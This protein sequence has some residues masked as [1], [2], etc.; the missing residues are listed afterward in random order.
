MASMDKMSVVAYPWGVDPVSVDDLVR[1]AQRAQDLGFYSVNVPY[2]TVAMEADAVFA[3]FSHNHIVDPVVV[4]T[5]MLRETHSIR[6]ASDGFPLSLLPP[7]HWAKTIATLEHMAPGRVIAGFCLGYGEKMF[8][9]YGATLKQR[10]SRSNEQ[11]EIITRL[12]SDPRVDHHG[13]H[14]H[15]EDMTC[16]PKPATAPPI[17]W[18][19][20]EKS[21]GR[22]ARYA[23]CLDLF[24]PPLEE[25]NTIALK[26]REEN[27]RLGTETELG[28]WV[29]THVEA[30]KSMTGEDIDT[31][32]AGYY[33][34]DER[35]AAP[36]PRDVAVAGDPRQCA[37]KIAEYEGLGLTR[38]VLD[39]QNHGV[40]PVDTGIAQMELFAE[41]VAPL[42]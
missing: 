6:I 39:F 35:I 27:Q 22:A 15:L 18:A 41:R 37:D 5:A 10:A 28:S 19:G 31:R 13:K 30:T 40:D 3:S 12:W 7:Y 4:M 11:L 29:Y 32:F 42:L 23:T 16:E 38:F 14:Y 21:I 17:W 36:R 8:S 34:S 20:G 1:F 25:V 2:V 9:A 33:F 24:L 26:L